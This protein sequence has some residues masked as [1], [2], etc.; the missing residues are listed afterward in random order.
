MFVSDSTPTLHQ[1]KLMEPRTLDASETKSRII[2]LIEKKTSVNHFMQDA[3]RETFVF[4]ATFGTDGYPDVRVLLVAAND[5][6]DA[7]WFATDAGC[8]KIAQL[9]KNPKAAIYGY[10]GETMASEFRLFGTVE[11]LSDAD[12][13]R[14]V[15][16]DDFIEHWP[17]GVDS[18]DM[19]VLRFN[20]DSGL[21]S[22][23]AEVMEIGKF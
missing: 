2:Q 13:R 23:Y 4:L 20:T 18:P 5:G 10:D 9:Q 22:N 3:K 7:I 21:Y 19:I 8:G 1:E 16:R 15:W 12:S 14:K 6:V 17:D 11:L